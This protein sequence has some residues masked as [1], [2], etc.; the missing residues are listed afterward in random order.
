MQLKPNSI[1]S[2]ILKFDPATKTVK[3]YHLLSSWGF[4]DPRKTVQTF[5]CNKLLKFIGFDQK[6]KVVEK[7]LHLP[8]VEI[9]LTRDNTFEYLFHLRDIIKVA[10]LCSD[11]EKIPKQFLEMVMEVTQSNTSSLAGLINSFYKA[12]VD[13]KLGYPTLWSVMIQSHQKCKQCILPPV[14][15]NTAVIG[16]EPVRRLTKG[17]MTYGS[18]NNLEKR[19]KEYGDDDGVMAF[20]FK[21]DTKE[22]TAK[23]EKIIKTKMDKYALAMT[24]RYFSI[25]GIVQKNSDSNM[26]NEEA[27]QKMMIHMQMYQEILR[28]IYET[29]PK[30]RHDFA[31]RCGGI[32]R[33]V[34]D[35]YDRK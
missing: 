22:D 18:T 8:V 3:L 31:K 25:D 16:G 13:D 27:V 7:T 33:D 32:F 35:L 12:L 29:F 19:I 21:S 1:K 23:I 10:K 26:T 9:N 5:K 11:F 30:Y 15:G 2:D 17:T 24:N 6:S 4:D 34:L 14:D 28:E 20:V